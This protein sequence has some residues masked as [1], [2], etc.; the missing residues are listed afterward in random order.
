MALTYRVKS[1]TSKKT[2]LTQI[3]VAVTAQTNSAS[4]IFTAAT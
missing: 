4:E 3:I 1:S 2:F